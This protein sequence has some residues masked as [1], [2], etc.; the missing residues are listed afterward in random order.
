MQL[1]RTPCP[2]VTFTRPVPIAIVI[3]SFEPGGTERQMIE[4]VRRLDRGRWEVHLCC[5]HARGQ[6]FERAAEAATS[7][8]EFPIRSFWQPHTM[9]Q[10]RAFA[11]WCRRSRISVVQTSELYSN[12]FALPAAALARVRVRIGSRREINA[13]KSPGQIALQRAAYACAHKVVANAKAAADRLLRE[14]VPAS[15]VVVIPNGLD[16]TQF[17][18]PRSR[19]SHRR[20]VMVA[21]LRPEKGHDTL[22]DAAIL[23]LE[24]FP[25]AHFDIVGNGTERDRLVA[26]ARTKGVAGAFS[27]LGHCEDVPARLCAADV[28]VLPS[29][30]EA[31]PNAVLEAMAAGLPVVASAVGGIL[32]VVQDNHTGLL[33]SPGR[34]DALADALCRLLSDPALGAR[35]SAAGRAVVETRYSFERMVDSLEHLYISELTRSGVR[36]GFPSRQLDF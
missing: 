36:P 23:V 16:M 7:V 2:P 3:P 8:A 4:L 31:F 24:R 22:I 27:F 5:L 17:P 34:P 25:D 6:W 29:R 9:T 18:T 13:G 30:S 35:L 33:V 12:I 26:Y 15:R 20:I 10:M 11:D 32:E 14:R 21:N 1:M 19:V 28:F